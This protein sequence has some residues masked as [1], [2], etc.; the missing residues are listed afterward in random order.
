MWVHWR[1]WG[2]VSGGSDSQLRTPLHADT[3]AKQPPCGYIQSISHAVPHHKQG[4]K[5]GGGRVCVRVQNC[6]C[7]YDG[8]GG[9]NERRGIRR[10]DRSSK[11]IMTPSH[12]YLRL[13]L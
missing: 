9:V 4:Q 12:D 10:R 11:Q 1:D 5:T 7:G 13:P 8:K 3:T 2:V 6:V